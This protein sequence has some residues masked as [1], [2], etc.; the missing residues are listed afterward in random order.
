MVMDWNSPA[1]QCLVESILRVPQPSFKAYVQDA[2]DEKGGRITFSGGERN[3]EIDLLCSFFGSPRDVVISRPRAPATLSPI[4]WH[5][6]RSKRYVDGSDRDRLLQIRNC[7]I[8]QRYVRQW[9]VRLLNIERIV[10]D[11][12]GFHGAVSPFATIE[13][14]LIVLPKVLYE[15]RQGRVKLLFLGE[16]PQVELLQFFSC[17]ENWANL[18]QL[19]PYTHRRYLHTLE[20]ST[21]REELNKWLKDEIARIFDLPGVETRHL[22]ELAEEGRVYDLSKKTILVIL[23]AVAERWSAVSRTGDQI[24]SAHALL[25]DCRLAIQEGCEYVD[26][27]R[28]DLPGPY[29]PQESDPEELHGKM[30]AFLLDIGLAETVLGPPKHI[31]AQG[32][33]GEAPGRTDRIEHQKGSQHQGLT[34]NEVM[35]AY[36]ANCHK[37]QRRPTLRDCVSWS[38]TV[39]CPYAKTTLANTSTWKGYRTTI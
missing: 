35:I 11:L 33:Y 21:F 37:S 4:M 2:L 10:Q 27:Y 12:F 34:A 5:A 7:F 6:E 31:E 22:D 13:E 36:L 39:D 26:G 20:V 15:I 16:H 28:F 3:A 32:G 1:L 23:A 17:A 8:R 18:I 38:K 9:G 14:R 25:E 29:V 19:H 24:K 30:Q